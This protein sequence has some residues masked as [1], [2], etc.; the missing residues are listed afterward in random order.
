MDETLPDCDAITV[1][2]PSVSI[3]TEDRFIALSK[4]DITHIVIQLTDRRLDSIMESV[5]VQYEFNKPWPFWFFIGKIVS[6]A[7]FN[8]DQQLEWLNTVRIRTREFIA[9][10]NAGR[11]ETD[12]N[13]KLQVI[14]VDFAK[15][16]PG[17]E[18]ELFW[19]PARGL[20][21][22]KVQE[23]LDLSTSSSSLEQRDQEQYKAQ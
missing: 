4:T 12:S 17:K 16:Q 11:K 23:W 19:K 6:K 20:I 8:N 2:V 15:P 7:F 5:G 10:T 18:L 3:T 13:Q 22:Q 14:E 1:P 9:F 21:S